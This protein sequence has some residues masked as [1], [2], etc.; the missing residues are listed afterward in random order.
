MID[1]LKISASFLALAGGI[2]Y[3][4]LSVLIKEAY[5]AGVTTASLIAYQS[6]FGVLVL[7]LITFR[8]QNVS[9]LTWLATSKLFLVGSLSG[10]T[11]ILYYLALLRLPAA[12]AIILLFQFTWLG[13]FF[14]F[15][16]ERRKPG[17]IHILALAL[18]IPGTY[19]AVGLNRFNP[20]ALPWSGVIPGLLSAVT[21]AGYIYFTGRVT[22]PV[23]AWKRSAVIMTG[24]L[25]TNLVFFPP[26]DF[27]SDAA[28]PALYGYGTLIGIFGPI[29]PTICLTYGVPVIGGGMAA[30]LG[31]VELPV[32]IL[33]AYFFLGEKIALWQFFGVATI[34]FGIVL[35]QSSGLFNHKFFR[36]KHRTSVKKNSPIKPG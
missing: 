36:T 25:L 35:S 3:G 32:V 1:V 22:P 23:S 17:V 31:S 27:V 7:W 2:S 21:Y 14:E 30:I 9:K 28:N 4:L 6:L 19:L 5:A 18:L 11:S 15:I 12:I 16:F 8:Q 24:A 29:I 10:L 34:L 13:S 20:L 26:V 33:L